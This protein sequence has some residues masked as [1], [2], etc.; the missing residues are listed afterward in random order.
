MFPCSIAILLS[1]RFTGLR[2]SHA[3]SVPATLSVQRCRISGSIRPV[4]STFTP[5]AVG[6]WRQAFAERALVAPLPLRATEPRGELRT[7]QEDLGRVVE[8]QE[9]GD[10]GRRRTEGGRLCRM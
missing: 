3:T 5:V 7:E 10:E 1:F 8:P 4:R 9:Q 2:S 6:D